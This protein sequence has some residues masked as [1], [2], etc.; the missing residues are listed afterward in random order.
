MRYDALS[1]MMAHSF[2]GRKVVHELDGVIRYVTDL[3]KPKFVQP[4][5]PMVRTL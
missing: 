5:I 2:M 4:R 1:L 3:R